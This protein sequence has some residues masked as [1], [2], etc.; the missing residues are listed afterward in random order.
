MIN[1]LYELAVV[2]PKDAM[3]FVALNPNTGVVLVTVLPLIT[4][5]SP[6]ERV[7]APIDV[8]LIVPP[9]IATALAAWVA[10]VPRPS[11]VRAAEAVVAPV[12]PLAK[13]N[14]PPKVNV[15]LEVIGPPVKVRPVVPPEPSTEVT[16]PTPA[17]EFQVGADA[18]L[19]V[20]T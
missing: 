19:E 17:T 9:V 3:V 16:V 2:V 11:A 6:V 7:V 8:P 18:P 10:I 13:A 12:P 1:W 14:V 20:N 4:V 15:P 5:K